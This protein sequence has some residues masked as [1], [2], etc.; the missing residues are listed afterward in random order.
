MEYHNFKKAICAH[1]QISI[2]QYFQILLTCKL[3]QI[4]LDVD[5]ELTNELLDNVVVGASKVVTNDY[6]P[7]GSYV[8]QLDNLKST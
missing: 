4:Y 2:F 8:R 1:S 6:M 5:V 3:L 7:Y